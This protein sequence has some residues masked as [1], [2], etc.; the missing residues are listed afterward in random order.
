MVR[1][2]FL[3]RRNLNW[4]QPPSDP[5]AADASF[6]MLHDAFP[7]HEG[8]GDHSCRGLPSNRPPEERVLLLGS[9]ASNAQQRATNSPARVAR[10][11]PGCGVWR[12]PSHGHCAP[13]EAVSDG[14]LTA[15]ESG[16]PALANRPRAADKKGKGSG[17]APRACRSC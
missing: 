2:L 11:E 12:R 17:L 6:S 7:S 5:V 9:L 8:V 14:R 15:L 4:G 16:R 1:F 10:G 13:V 3:L